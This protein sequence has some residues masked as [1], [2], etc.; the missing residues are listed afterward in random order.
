MFVPQLS[1][2][3]HRYP[4][5]QKAMTEKLNFII[6]FNFAGAFQLLHAGCRLGPL[7]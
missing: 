1:M 7:S 5:Q 6:I 4:R 2:I 3:L